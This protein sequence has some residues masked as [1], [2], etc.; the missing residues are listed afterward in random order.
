MKMHEVNESVKFIKSKTNFKP[1]Y[2]II[3]GTGL[4]ALAEQISNKES[5]SYSEIPHFPVSTVELHEGRLIFGYLSGVPVVIMQGRFHYYEGY[6]MKQITFPVRVMKLLGIQRLFISNISGGLNPDFKVSDM[7]IIKDHINL[8]YESPL[9]GSNLD[10]LGDRFPDM[11]EPY[12]KVMIS[13]GLDIA[14]KAGYPIYKGVYVSVL[15]PDLK[16]PAEYQYLRTIGADSVGMSTVPEVIVARHMKLPV[17]AISVITDICYG[18]IRK[19][20]VPKIIEAA[21]NA[22][23]RITHVISALVGEWVKDN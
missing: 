23:P 14:K 16:T 10:E 4:G 11:S 5:I 2:G 17:F 20:H 12:D 6:N 22:E 3:L 15:G 8:Q 21:K 1:V 13:K 18:E 19:I 7:M 9:T